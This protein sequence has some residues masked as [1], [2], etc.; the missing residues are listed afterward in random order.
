MFQFCLTGTIGDEALEL[1]GYRRHPIRRTG[2]VRAIVPD[3]CDA[4][5][6]EL[7][8]LASVRTAAGLGPAS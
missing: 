4:N 5:P 8:G 2:I 1:L 7:A 6:R 3:L